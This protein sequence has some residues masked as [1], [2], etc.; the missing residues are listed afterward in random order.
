MEPTALLPLR[1][2]ARWGFFR[3]KNPTNLGTKGQHA[4]S[5]PPKPLD[6]WNKNNSFNTFPHKDKTEGTNIS[7]NLWTVYLRRHKLIIHRIQRQP[8][9]VYRNIKVP[10]C[11]HCRCGKA[12]SITY[13]ECVSVALVIQHA[14]HMHP[15]I[16]S[17]AAC[18]VL[19]I[20]STL[21]HKGHDF[22][23]TLRDVNCAFWFS[24]Q[25]LSETFLILRR[26]KRGMIK[27]VYWSS[28]KVPAILTRF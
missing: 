24:L 7:Q 6:I 12:I 3:P 9:Y 21:S 2:K 19:Q 10:S 23:K 26:Y 20:S 11:S 15:I 1:R 18:P 5:R 8:M 14:M 27:N 4:T 13:S 25:L 16:L 22:R 28:C 17:S